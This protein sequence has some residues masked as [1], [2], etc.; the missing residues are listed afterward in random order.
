MVAATAV[1]AADPPSVSARPGPVSPSEWT[2]QQELTSSNGVQDGDFGNAAVS[3]N[4]I[5]VGAPQH[6]Y[7]G[8]PDQGLAYIFTH[9][10]SGW[11]QDQIL[12]ASDG[13]RFDQ[14]GLAVAIAGSSILVGAPLHNVGSNA[15]QGAVYVFADEGRKW[16]QTGEITAPDGDAG[17]HFGGSVAMDGDKA[18][19]GAL[20]HGQ[21]AAYFLSDVHGTW[22]ASQEVTD[23]NPAGT[24]SNQFGTSV[25]LSGSE[26]IVSAPDA[27]VGS[28]PQQ[29]V[30]FVY[31]HG[32]NGWA[33]AQQITAAQGSS[34]LEFGAG[35]GFSPAVAIAGNTA[36]VGAMYMN[37]F[38]GTAYVFTRSRKGWVQTQQLTPSSLSPAAGFGTVVAVEGKTLVIGAQWDGSQDQGSVYTYAR[39][40]RVWTQEQ[41]LTATNAVGGDMLG[42]SVSMS[43]TTLVVG[44]FH[45]ETQTGAAYV[46]TAGH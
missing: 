8:E 46:F 28:N 33:E 44:A 17:D 30:A 14:F 11:T 27:T 13:T 22:R 16:R 7:N 23:P 39:F 36:V 18:V 34:P 10:T 38:Q 1:L 12:T 20:F 3:G 25:A 31:V 43:G 29:G 4:T 2:Q 41:Q 35:S 5:V 24:I 40:G 45:V 37:S 19:V 21:G 15:E 32:H 6:D 42:S 9:T 26:A